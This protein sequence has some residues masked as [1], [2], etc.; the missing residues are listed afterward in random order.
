MEYPNTANTARG[1]EVNLYTKQTIKK[2][3]S[4]AHTYNTNGIMYGGTG[5]IQKYH[6]L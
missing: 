4:C 3:A 1:I 2:A 6:K 5:N